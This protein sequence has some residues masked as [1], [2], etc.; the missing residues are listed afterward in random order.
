M[1]PIV[2]L[3]MEIIKSYKNY[4]TQEND[5]VVIVELTEKGINM[6]DEILE[7]P[8]KIFCYSGMG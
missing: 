1:F 8:E 5:R 6:K 3:W 7:V 4:R 2:Y